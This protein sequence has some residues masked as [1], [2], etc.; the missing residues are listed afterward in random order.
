MSGWEKC[1]ENEKNI[2]SSEVFEK[3][4]NSKNVNKNKKPIVLSKQLTIWSL[5]DSILFPKTLFGQMALI[6][7]MNLNDIKMWRTEKASIA[8]EIIKRSV[9]YFPAFFYNSPAEHNGVVNENYNGFCYAFNDDTLSEDPLIEGPLIEDPSIED[10]L[11]EDPL[12][13]D[14]LSVETTEN[15][16]QTNEGQQM[17]EIAELQTKTFP[18]S[19]P[20][21]L[22]TNDGNFVNIPNYTNGIMVNGNFISPNLN[23][24]LELERIPVRKVSYHFYKD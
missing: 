18:V 3:V 9:N 23:V 20:K 1:I 11:M 19:K 10:P 16:F 13:E 22:K 15:G 21:R 24:R 5:L 4:I 6:A 12:I 7:V 17:E 8:Q 2:F 14:P